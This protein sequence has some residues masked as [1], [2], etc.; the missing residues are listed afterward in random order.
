V[1]KTISENPVF[2]SGSTLSWGT[3]FAMTI[4]NRARPVHQAE[5]SSEIYPKLPLAIQGGP[6]LDFHPIKKNEKRTF[7]MEADRRRH[8]AK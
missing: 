2:H 3:D 8:G 1:K 7:Q 6:Q 4:D 5:E